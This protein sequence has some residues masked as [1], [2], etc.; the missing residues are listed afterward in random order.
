[1]F[2]ENTSSE[3]S[4]SNEWFSPSTESARFLFSWDCW[5][6]S[7]CTSHERA[8][9]PVCAPEVH[10]ITSLDSL[11]A[12]GVS[13]AWSGAA[14][15]IFASE[16]AKKGGCQQLSLW[17]LLTMKWELVGNPE[18]LF[19]EL[20]NGRSS[21]VCTKHS[22]RKQEIIA[23][24][25]CHTWQQIHILVAVCSQKHFKVQP[26]NTTSAGQHGCRT[27]FWNHHFARDH[28][29]QQANEA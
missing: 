18:G 26:I 25:A 14:S 15:R 3:N 5:L 19:S 29:Q 2:F 23:S 12:D 27:V 13:D 11:A 1:M 10:A 17:L 24:Y 7:A 8:W 6:L 16:F 4:T 9:S 22:K 20:C 28:Q 21:C